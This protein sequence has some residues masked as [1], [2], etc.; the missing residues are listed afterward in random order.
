MP[1]YRN[2]PSQQ[3]TLNEKIETM[4]IEGKEFIIP[5]EFRQKVL[6]LITTWKFSFDYDYKTD[7]IW[8]E[9]V[10]ISVW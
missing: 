9:N 6:D 5:E 10:V 1:V 2:I 3:I 4:E 8:T 7:E